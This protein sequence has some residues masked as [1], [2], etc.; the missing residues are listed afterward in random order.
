[1]QK[2]VSGVIQ[3][4]W[5]NT[6][7]HLLAHETGMTMLFNIQVGQKNTTALLWMD[8]LCYCPYNPLFFITEDFVFF[9]TKIAPQPL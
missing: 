9:Q 8:E 6:Q 3:R 5:G 4:C 1:M 2:K 7:Q